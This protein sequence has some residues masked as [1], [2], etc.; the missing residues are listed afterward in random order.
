LRGSRTPDDVVIRE[1][2][3]YTQTGK[4]LRKQLASDVL[5]SGA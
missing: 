2:L 1:E 3:P 5:Q 4:L